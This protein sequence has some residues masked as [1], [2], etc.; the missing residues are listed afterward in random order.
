MGVGAGAFLHVGAFY[1]RVRV[2]QTFEKISLMVNFWLYF[3]LNVMSASHR[4]FSAQSAALHCIQA[5]LQNASEHRSLAQIPVMVH[6]ESR[7]EGLARE[8][9]ME[10]LGRELY[11]AKETITELNL[12]E[13]MQFVNQVDELSTSAFYKDLAQI[14]NPDEIRRLPARIRSAMKA[15]GAKR[16]FLLLKQGRNLHTVIADWQGNPLSES[17]RR[18]EVMRLIRC[19]P[20]TPKAPF[21][22]YPADDKFDEWIENARRNWARKTSITPERYQIVCAL[23]LV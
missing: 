11:L 23:A 12:D 13:V 19:L 15:K 8:Y 9:E 2:E 22:D 3:R 4:F 10:K 6:D 21:D 17:Y 1:L 5:A 7:R 14:R 16:V 20:E 18:D